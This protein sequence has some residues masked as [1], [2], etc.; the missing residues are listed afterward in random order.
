MQ[1]EFLRAADVQKLYGIRRGTLYNLLN[2]GAVK[3]VVLRRQG[4]AGG[5]RLIH[6]AS[7][8]DYLNSKLA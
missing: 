6:V 5:C 2:E 3:S 4:C 7:L 8:R 1:P